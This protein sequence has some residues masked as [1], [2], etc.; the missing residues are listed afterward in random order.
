MP[1]TTKAPTL[2]DIAKLNIRACI[3]RSVYI[4]L[5]QRSK[6]D[7]QRKIATNRHMVIT[8]EKLL[9][10][11]APSFEAYAD[12][13]TLTARVE[14]VLAAWTPEMS[15]DLSLCTNFTLEAPALEKHAM[16]LEASENAASE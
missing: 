8:V 6:A 5:H 16:K 13:T 11:T 4:A 1:P 2:Q 14:G 12:L 15:A 10:S 7:D 3:L 9:L